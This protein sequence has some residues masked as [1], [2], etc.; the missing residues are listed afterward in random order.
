M[1]VTELMT[2]RGEHAKY[3]GKAI[4]YGIA[5][6]LK[7]EKFRKNGLR[8]KKLGLCYRCLG[9]DHLGGECP[10]SRV[11]NID[12]C[13]DR[14]NRLLHG[15]RNR[16][17]SQSRSLG[18]QPQGTRPQG[19]QSQSTQ[20]QLARTIQGR[21]EIQSNRD[22]NIL[23]QGIREQSGGLSTEGDANTNSTS[24]KI[25]K[26]EKV[27]LRTVPAILK[28]GKKRILVNCFLDEGSDTTY[29]NEDVVEELGVKGRKS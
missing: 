20:L 4:L 1:E 2:K 7:V 18:T 24:L 25:Q 9:D 6:S 22:D 12:G 27:A 29:V 8:R 23:S 5:M 13:R 28:H 26:A 14:H 16:N 19:T 15:N 11:C 21:R 3:V 10:R 17:N